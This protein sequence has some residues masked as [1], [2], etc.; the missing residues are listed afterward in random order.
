MTLNLI[1]ENH[2]S[3]HPQPPEL[4]PGLMP[5][6]T[7]RP[8]L[9]G[10]ALKSIY[11]PSMDHMQGG[12]LPGLTPLLFY[13]SLSAKC[14]NIPCALAPNRIICHLSGYLKLTLAVETVQGMFSEHNQMVS[15]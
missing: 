1:G 10:R 15:S 7:Q 8:L 11:L 14:L 13:V 2:P 4:S 9:A 6:T 12:Q 3:L 5:H